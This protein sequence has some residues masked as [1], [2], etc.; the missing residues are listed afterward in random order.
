MLALSRKKDE[1]IIIGNGIEV[2]ILDVTG[3]T[4]KLGIDAPREISIHR[5]EVY[6]EIKAANEESTKLNVENFKNI[7]KN[8]K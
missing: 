7:L 3:D 4:V 5:K 1:S 8:N 6:E 2:K